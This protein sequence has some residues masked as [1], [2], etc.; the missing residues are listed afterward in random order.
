L[1]VS[2]TGR[3]FDPSAVQSNSGLGL[4]SMA[5]RARSVGGQLSVQS[6]VNQGTRIEVSIPVRQPAADGEDSTHAGPE[7][8]GRSPG[9]GGR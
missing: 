1:S 5:E 4:V 2:D 9:H 6:T 7:A 3:G 8:T